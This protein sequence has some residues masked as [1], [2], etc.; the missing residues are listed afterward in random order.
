ML[1][2]MSSISA[3]AR[4]RLLTATVALALLGLGGVALAGAAAAA[5]PAAGET[6]TT[7]VD[8]S[9]PGMAGD[10]NS[11]TSSVSADG[12][13]VAFDSD[14]TNLIGISNRGTS[15]VY[16][17]DMA[18][19]STELVGLTSTGSLAGGGPSV[20]P[21]ISADGRFVAF[22]SS[23][24]DLTVPNDRG[25]LASQVYVRDMRTG[26]TLK[27]SRNSAGSGG[28]DGASSAPSISADGSLV[29]F[30]SLAHNLV[31][32]IT[33][34][35]TQ[36]FVSQNAPDPKTVLVSS[37]DGSTNT[38][39]NDDSVQAAI[40]GNGS[41]VAFVSAASNVTSVAGNGKSQV[42]LRD[43]SDGMTKLLTFSLPDPTFVAG[44]NSN[45]PSVSFD[46]SRVAYGSDALDLALP[47]SRLAPGQVFVF[48]ALSNSNR[49]VSFDQSNTALA[50]GLTSV[51]TIS[52]DGTLVA[53]SSFAT[54]LTDAPTGGNTEVYLR[55]L[56]TSKTS[57]VSAAFG[58]PAKAANGRTANAVIS[59]DGGYVAFASF[60]PD[61]SAISTD[62]RVI[63][64]YLRGVRAV[65]PTPTPTPTVE[66]TTTPTSTAGPGTPAPTNTATGSGSTA[67]VVG[68]QGG[69][70]GGSERLAS[71]GMSQ[72]PIIAAGVAA[73]VL[74]LVGGSILFGAHAARRRKLAAGAGAGD[75]DATNP[76]E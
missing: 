23:A 9:S 64:T 18:R 72:A 51:P 21:A 27:L 61:A 76:A 60:A 14:A 43:L 69:S 58:D 32:G 68:G 8:A 30:E 15:Q 56:N 55:D 11:V 3:P 34:T 71:T 6:L 2:G 12:R 48:D 54:N 36:V 22:T 13:F 4:P 44:D 33:T 49:L 26:V 24:P 47:K 75:A 62:G 25:N 73:A 57:L 28:G 59:P 52:A 5:V 29:A 67:G 16:L 39:P 20:D 65:G 74:A 38:P 10:R 35:D 42:Y 37:V 41:V 40:S 46:G 50:D 17:R 63:Q 66:P 19:G 45:F 31:S 70:G 7:S 53:F 1:T